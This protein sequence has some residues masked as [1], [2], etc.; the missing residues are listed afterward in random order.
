MNSLSW[1]NLIK[2]IK[3]DPNGRRHILSAWNPAELHL[4]SL[5]PCHAFSQFYV[6]ENKPKCKNYK[7]E[8]TNTKNNDITFYK[9]HHIISNHWYTT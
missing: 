6:S 1:K 8:D 2:G 5:P 7:N 3:S 4:M 9:T